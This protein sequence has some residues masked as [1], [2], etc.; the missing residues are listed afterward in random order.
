MS[1]LKDFILTNKD[2]KIVGV[3][4]FCDEDG[5]T[6]LNDTLSKKRINFVFGIIKNQIKIRDDFKTRSYGELH[7]LS[8][9]K[10]ENRKVTLFFI[11]K[12]DFIREDE[13][14]GIKKQLS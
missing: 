10:A 13:I 14:L 1:N 12:D 11:E 5:T 2:I 9:I 3:S 4:G 6:I 7:Q 8:K